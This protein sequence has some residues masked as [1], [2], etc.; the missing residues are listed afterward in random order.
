LGQDRAVI[1]GMAGPSR[2]QGRGDG[3]YGM[4]RRATRDYAARRS[5][6]RILEPRQGP[7]GLAD[8]RSRAYFAQDPESP[9]N[10]RRFGQKPAASETYGA[11]RGTENARSGGGRRPVSAPGRPRGRDGQP[12]DEASLAELGRMRRRDGEVRRHEQAHQSAGGGLVTR[13][14][15]YRYARG[16]DGQ[17]Y[18]VAGDV[19]IDASPARTPEATAA[20]MR[21]V[22]TAALAPADPSAQDRRVAAAATQR[23]QRA[24][25]EAAS[26][27]SDGGHD[28]PAPGQDAENSAETSPIGAA[29]GSSGPSD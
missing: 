24:L 8:K 19:R 12:L 1:G 17:R 10:K 4:G 5:V 25:L 13:G 15:S 28:R 7:A 26:T 21:R 20:K 14:A 23:E 3:M 18:A 2:R 16:P 29:S 6:D 22:R 11:D 27:K 9:E